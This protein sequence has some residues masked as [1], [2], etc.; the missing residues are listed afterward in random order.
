MTNPK[1]FWE[2]KI[3]SWE[4]GRYNLEP[5]SRNTT[6]ETFANKGSGSLRFRIHKTGEMLSEF[7]EGKNVVELGCG[8][9]LLT[10][11]LMD[12]GARSYLGIDIAEA[13]IFTARDVHQDLIKT[14]TVD[15]VQGKVD[16][17]P[18]QPADIIFSLGLL[19]WLTDAELQSM[20]AWRPDAN[21]FHAIAE[22]R[23]SLTQLIHKMYVYVAYGHRTKGYVPRYYTIEDML[24][25]MACLTHKERYVYRSHKLTFGA[26]VSTF[27]IGEPV[28]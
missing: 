21:H 27:P 22:K 1:D 15:F 12:A 2:Q 26:F 5:D 11:A 20:F 7:V 25:Y 4:N 14:G 9:G 17:L 24:G 16:E 8:R 23:F 3:L 18:K 13:A 10:R 19:D 6:F 28:Q